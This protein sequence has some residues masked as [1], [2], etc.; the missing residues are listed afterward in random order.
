MSS[1]SAE[2]KVSPIITPT[3]AAVLMVEALIAVAIS[4]AEPVRVVTALASTTLE[5]FEA[6][7]FKSAA[8]AMPDATVTATFAAKL[9][10]VALI[11]VAI[12]AAKP[13]SL[14]TAVANMSIVVLASKVFRSAALAVESVTVIV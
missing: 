5:V 6:I 7:V 3:F 11:A 4:V 2:T 1:V 12:S 8:D 10:V 13:V 9:I 14:V